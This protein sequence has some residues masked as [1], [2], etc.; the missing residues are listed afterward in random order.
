M[1]DR[2]SRRAEQ[3]AK[4]NAMPLG[5]R[6]GMVALTAATAIVAVALVSLLLDGEI[7]A[8]VLLI[9]L[10]AGL[11]SSYQYLWVPTRRP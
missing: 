8:I 10:A 4:I 1:T 2:T 5:K 6:I 9:G 11:G 3:Q 7:D